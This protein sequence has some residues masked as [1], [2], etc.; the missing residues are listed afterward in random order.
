MPTQKGAGRQLAQNL[1]R[2]RRCLR[3]P[4]SKRFREPFFGTPLYSFWG[5]TEVVGS[6]TF[7]SKTG[8]VTKPVKGA[9]VRLCNKDGKAVALGEIGELQIRG[10]NV[11]IGYW[12]SPDVI[13]D[14]TTDGWYH[15]G[16]LMREDEDGELWFV[17]RKRDIIVRGGSNISPVEVER[18]LA[19]HPGRE[20]CRRCGHPG[21][22]VRTAHRR[23]RRTD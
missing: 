10:P 16:D 14:V 20:G 13:R 9:E 6:L 18:A 17:S 2:R 19:T 22:S 3:A 1:R 11:A 15:T 12:E 5:A 23:F 8:P 4:R 21:R 7:V